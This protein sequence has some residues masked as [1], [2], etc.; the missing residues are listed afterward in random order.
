MRV[1]GI[2]DLDGPDLAPYRTLKRQ[3]DHFRRGIF[4]AEGAIV[5]DRL[6]RSGLDVVSILATEAWLEG[7]RA[8]VEARPGPP[9]VYV[10]PPP[11]LERLTGFDYHQGVLAVGRC[12]PEPSLEAVLASAPA[13]AP[14]A[15]VALDGITSSEN[16]GVLVR[17]ASALGATAL[18][19]GERSCSPWLRRAVRS[20]M[21]GVLF[22]PVLHV[23]D[24][25]RALAR[26]RS[27]FGFRAAAA[28]AGGGTPLEEHRFA[29]E[30]AI[31]LGHESE[32]ISPAVRAAC[33]EAVTIPMRRD[34]D[35]LNVATAAAVLLFE[36]RRQLGLRCRSECVDSRRGRGDRR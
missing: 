16:T 32:G 22:L 5:V 28:V 10:G 9:P 14:R 15:L 35:S 34:L 13:R 20:S 31:V 3:V 26:L 27:E 19:A 23:P 2:S 17:A 33:D 12:P 4:V 25:A 30:T 24:L 18:L 36:F 6:L 21:G 29:P 1:I 8:L 7:N 11:L